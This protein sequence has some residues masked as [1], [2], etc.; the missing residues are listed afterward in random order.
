MIDVVRKKLKKSIH[1]RIDIADC[2]A[3]EMDFVSIVIFH[4]CSDAIC[5]S[6]EIMRALT[7]SLIPTAEPSFYQTAPVASNS[8]HVHRNHGAPQSITST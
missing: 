2:V 6:A 8:K 1:I 7:A 3:F 4:R 5:L